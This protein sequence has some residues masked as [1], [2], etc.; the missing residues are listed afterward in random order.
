MNAL[1]SDTPRLRKVTPGFLLPA[2]PTRRPLDL[3]A[4]PGFLSQ[5]GWFARRM[6]DAHEGD[7]TIR[8]IGLPPALD[9]AWRIAD[10][11]GDLG[12]VRRLAALQE[13]QHLDTG[14]GGGTAHALFTIT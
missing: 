6:I 2:D 11:G 9:L 14:S 3:Q 12:H 8:A 4:H 1:V 13:T 10:E 5:M 7:E